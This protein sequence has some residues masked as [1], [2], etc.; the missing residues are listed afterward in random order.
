MT[1][2]YLLLLAASA[3]A[4]TACQNEELSSVNGQSEQNAIGFAAVSSNSTGA[5]TSIIT[6]ANFTNQSFEVV[7]FNATS[8]KQFMGSADAG[9][10]IVYKSDA[11]DYD[12]ADS[13]AWWPSDGSKLDFYAISPSLKK[14]GEGDN[15]TA[16]INGTKDDGTKTIAYSLV[17][18]YGTATGQT[19]TDLMYAT[20]FGYDKSVNSS[21]VKLTFHHAL[22]QIIFKGRTSKSS[23]EVTVNSIK[24]HNIPNSGTFTIPTTLASEGAD[25]HYAVAPAQA[26]WTATALTAANNFTAKLTGESITTKNTAVA[27]S[28]TE[29]PL[30]VIPQTV[31]QWTTTVNAPVTIATADTNKQ[32]YLEISMKLTQNGQYIIG[33]A[34]AYTT[35][36]VPF[37][38]T[39]WKPGKRYIYTL[40]FGGG[41]DADGKPVLSPIYFEP[42]VEDWT[43]TDL[44]ILN[45]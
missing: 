26:N 44:G 39:D 10:K 12:C 2:N 7:A 5:R 6:N 18:E 42:E 38:N 31:T 8:G 23:L 11:W 1:K 45:L 15:I 30:V 28:D 16:T 21:K 22:S 34:D 33:S 3:C 43:D 35:V 24:V 37:G 27:L 14:T 9:V 40:V 13:L 4:V 36:Y 19:N 17:D 32:G 25:E 20:A 29:S 41:Y